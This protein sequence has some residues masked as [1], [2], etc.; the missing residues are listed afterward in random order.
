MAFQNGILREKEI[1]I[2]NLSYKC[3]HPYQKALVCKTLA[4]LLKAVP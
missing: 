3:K 1:T 2:Q 4:D